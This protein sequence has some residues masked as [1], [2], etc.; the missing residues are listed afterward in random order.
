MASALASLAKAL[1]QPAEAIPASPTILRERLKGLTPAMVGMTTGRWRNIR[2]LVDWALDHAGLVVV[3][4]RSHEKPAAAWQEILTLLGGGPGK[5]FFLWRFA[6][7]SS[8]MGIAPSDVTDAVIARYEADLIERSLAVDPMRTPR[9]VARFWNETSASQPGWPQQRLAVPDNR[10]TRAPG[11]DAY[12]QSLVRDV[13]AWCAALGDTDPFTACAPKPLKP[14]SIETRRKQLRSY[15]GAL[16]EQGIDPREL[17]DLAS[18]V[19]PARARFA[20]RV[21]WERAGK[22]P[23][24]HTY[25]LASLAL[26]IARHWANLSKEDVSSIAEMARKVRPPTTALSGRNMARLRQLEDPVKL[27]ALIELPSALVAEATRLGRGSKHAAL[28]IQTAVLV[29]LLLQVPMRMAN[30]RCLRIGL[31]L[32][33]GQKG[34]ITISVPADDVKNGIAID[35]KLSGQTAA[36]LGLYLDTYRPQLAEGDSD[37]LF[38]GERPGTPKTAQGLRDQI[39]TVLADRVG[40]TFNPHSFRQLAAY[41]MLNAHPGAHGMVQRVLGHK[42]L[43]STMAFY[44]GLETPAALEHYDGLI[45]AH[46]AKPMATPGKRTAPART[47]SKPRQRRLG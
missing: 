21:F 17:V 14:T 41:I 32:R 24:H 2:S 13:E 19:T 36:L 31:H 18:V 26:M 4:A 30:L 34:A 46:R 47:G 16:V 44:S 6:R 10:P 33:R 43:H 8:R 5:H 22:K 15:L 11:W 3:P 20:L 29:E 12:P 23:T 39:Q 45:A 40:I 9:E 37:C 1:G 38:P 25:Q 7:W 27:Q 28:T 35:A 42:S